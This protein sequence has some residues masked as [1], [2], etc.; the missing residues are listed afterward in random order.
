MRVLITGI[1]GHIGSSFARWIQ[2]NHPETEIW[3]IDNFSC[4]FKESVPAGVKL[5]MANLAD[6]PNLPEVDYCWHFAAMAA[7]CLSPFVRRYHVRNNLEGAAVVLNAVLSQSGCKRFVFASSAAVYGAGKP[8]FSEISACVPHDPYG[9]GKLFVE[10]D[11]R[12]A[13]EQH[14]VDWCVLRP[15][16]I[17]GPGQNIWDRHRNVFGIWMRAALEGMPLRIYGD[18][19]Q[20]RAFSYIDDI[21][22]CLWQ[23]AVAPAVSRQIINL[24]GEKPVSI[25]G[26]AE[27]TA[28]VTGHWEIEHVAERHEV[29]ETFCTTEKSEALLGFQDRTRLVDGLTAMWNW[30]RDAWTMYP[31]RRGRKERETE[32]AVQWP[33]RHGISGRLDGDT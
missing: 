9:A 22:P 13:G 17:Y 15:H 33:G 32:L 14:G 29:K 21:L 30:G 8:P 3:G 24:G 18:G 31:E 27:L 10:T 28:E 7:E 20:K 5:I 23:A 16:N 25:R 2:A 11:L 4:G 19:L 12:I 26:A 6:A 1:A